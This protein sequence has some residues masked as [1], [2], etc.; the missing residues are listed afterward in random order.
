M[1][2]VAALLSCSAALAQNATGGGD[3]S[4]WWSM[5]RGVDGADIEPQKRLPADSNFS[6]LGVALG[7]SQFVQVGARLGTASQVIRGDASTGR[8]QACYVSSNSS[9]QVHLVFE[10]GEVD[11]A[12]YLFSGGPDWQHSELCKK[13]STIS[14][15]LK[16][17][18][19]L[20]LRQTRSQVEAILGKPTAVQANT[21]IYFDQVHIEPRDHS[22]PYDLTTY[23]EA[24][25]ADGKLNYLGVM[26]SETD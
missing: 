6:I 20:A 3:D 23:I 22:T 19:G 18:S 12:F 13:S 17:G 4:D 8:T 15:R 1:A 26:K 5:T 24:R 21:L 2:I 16:T 11:Y 9:P 7:D 25:F 10:Q 14:S